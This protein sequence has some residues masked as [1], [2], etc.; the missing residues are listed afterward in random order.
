MALDRATRLMLVRYA[1]HYETAGFLDGDPSWFMHQV[2]GDAN[3]E[4]VAF[5]ASGLSF[6][7]RRQFMPKIQ[8]LLDCADGDMDA[9]VRNGG[10][11]RDMPCGCADCFYRFFTH[12]DMHGFFC[13]YRRLMEEYGTLGE[14]VRRNAEG[15]GYRSIAAICRW[16]ATSG[17]GG[18]L[19]W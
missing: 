14:Y 17:S 11:E 2:D 10:F 1:T 15:D 9:W 7:N 13:A 6:G 12:A 16:F 18:V 4:A 8:R 5:V 3:R 19:H